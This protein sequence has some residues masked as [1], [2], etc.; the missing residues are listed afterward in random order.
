[1]NSYLHENIEETVVEEPPAEEVQAETAEAPPADDDRDPLGTWRIL[2]NPKKIQTSE[3]ADVSITI[4]L[5]KG[6]ILNKVE[7]H[8][9][10]KSTIFSPELYGSKENGTK[11]PR[12]TDTIW[13]PPKPSAKSRLK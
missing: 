12:A 10:F 11:L 1:M 4:V 9:K 5:G 2:E 8:T 7:M 6:E 13:K 3:G